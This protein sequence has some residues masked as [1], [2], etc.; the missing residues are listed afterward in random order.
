MHCVLVHL[1]CLLTNKP[2][3]WVFAMLHF[4]PDEVQVT[5]VEED[6]KIESNI[7][8]RHTHLYVRG[9]EWVETQGI[10]YAV[11]VVIIYVSAHNFKD[12][13]TQLQLVLEEH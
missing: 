13:H 4:T 6:D 11:T 9:Q 2:V 10:E 1:C 5:I 8:N 3:C 7:L 12:I